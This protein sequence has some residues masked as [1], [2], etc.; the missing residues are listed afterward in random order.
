MT[1]YVSAIP[2]YG[3]DYQ[4]EEAVREDWDQGKDFLT[5][6]MMVHGYVNKDDKPAN[7]QLNISYDRQMEIC[8]IPSDD[9]QPLPDDKY[10]D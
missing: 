9:E 10:L 5:Q 6:D 1:R 2:A 4:T 3:R 8:V 7:V